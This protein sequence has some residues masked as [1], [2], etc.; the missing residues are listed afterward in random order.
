MDKDGSTEGSPT[1]ILVLS[2]LVF[3]MLLAMVALEGVYNCSQPPPAPPLPPDGTPILVLS[4]WEPKDV[5]F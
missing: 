5:D 2:I 1:G 3:L 4:P